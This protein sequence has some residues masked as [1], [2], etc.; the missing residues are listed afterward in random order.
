M[1]RYIVIERKLALE[2]GAEYPSWW[3]LVLA[4]TP[5]QAFRKAEELCQ[6][7]LGREF[8]FRARDIKSWNRGS[9]W[10]ASDGSSVCYE[11]LKVDLNI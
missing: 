4:D 2:S 10:Q 6:Q 7:E 5:Q 3:R 8:Y 1:T 11:I 9:A